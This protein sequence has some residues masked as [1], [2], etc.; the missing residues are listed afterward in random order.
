[1]DASRI[2][3]GI[4][5][6]LHLDRATLA[7]LSGVSPSTVGRIEKGEL[8][9]TWG[10]LT[11][12]LESTGFHIY[13][14]RFVPTGDATAA[15]A[16]RLVLDRVLGGTS[17]NPSTSLMALSGPAELEQWWDRWRRAR[18]LSEDPT[19]LGIG[20]VAMTAAHTAREG[21]RAMPQHVVGDGRGWRELA[22]RIDQAGFEYAVSETVA[23][24]ESPGDGL[25]TIPRIYVSDPAM[26]ASVLR[27]QE[28]A[29][30]QGVPLVSAGWPE[31]DDVVVGHA[32]RFTT[33]GQAIMDGLTG[34][35]TE[36]RRA[37]RTL[38]RLIPEHL[39]IG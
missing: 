23:A 14:E 30:G 17:R 20:H 33:L 10:M 16:A 24:L 32:I 28:S 27:L 29:P 15:V 6:Q 1:M 5:M 36:Q 35:E 11:R 12:I 8:D 9:P 19:Q 3:I 37:E 2:L 21:R 26:V 39:R 38:L 22:L 25:A 34:E 13:G 18:W 4:R 31:L 7:R